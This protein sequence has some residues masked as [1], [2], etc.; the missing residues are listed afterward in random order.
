MNE[1][2]FINEYLLV[3]RCPNLL[4]IVSNTINRSSLGRRGFLL[5]SP[6]GRV[7]RGGTE[8]K[9]AEECCSLANSVCP[10]LRTTCPGWHPHPQWDGPSLIN[11]ESRFVFFLLACRPV[12]QRHLLNWQEE[13]LLPKWFESVSS[14]QNPTRVMMKKRLECVT[15]SCFLS[16]FAGGFKTWE[17]TLQVF[18]FQLTWIFRNLSLKCY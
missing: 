11:H 3:Y 18:R 17:S 10:A 7:V 15:W 6:W 5:L 14:W 2:L 4:S 9:I 16:G 8:A 12:L 13:V 1:C